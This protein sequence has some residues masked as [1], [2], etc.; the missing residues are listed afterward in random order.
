MK[1]VEPIHPQQRLSHDKHSS[2][3]L[4]QSLTL[5]SVA[6]KSA[7][8]SADMVCFSE[9]TFKTPEQTLKQTHLKGR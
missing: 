1:W 4:S 3:S 6:L 2:F 5:H 9:E 7:S 8:V